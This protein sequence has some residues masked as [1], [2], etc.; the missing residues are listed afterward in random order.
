MFN[1]FISF[2]KSL[3]LITAVT[4]GLIILIEIICRII[5]WVEWS[6]Y[7]TNLTIQ[8]NARWISDSTSY[9]TNRPFFLEYDHSS[10]YN[11]IGMRVRAKDVFMPEKKENDFWVFLFG[12]S[13][14][15]GMG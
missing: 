9:W 4:A 2:C 13:A 1:R 12:A 5:V 8:G 14:M 6:P 11:E 3:L 10:Q 15:A 7:H